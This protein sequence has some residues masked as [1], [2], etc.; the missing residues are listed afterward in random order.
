MR[1]GENLVTSPPKTSPLLQSSLL[2]VPRAGNL[3]APT[4]DSS[5]HLVHP[6]CSSPSQE[7][8]SQLKPSTDGEGAHV[9]HPLHLCHSLLIHQPQDVLGLMTGWP[10]PKMPFPTESASSSLNTTLSATRAA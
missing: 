5:R 3:G 10:L 6:V 2:L 7:S 8:S 4:C 9:H 1:L